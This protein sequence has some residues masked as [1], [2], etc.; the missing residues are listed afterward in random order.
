MQNNVL[1]GGAGFTNDS[2]DLVHLYLLGKKGPHAVLLMS[3]GTPWTVISLMSSH[4][5]SLEP[6]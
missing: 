1:S 5:F 3:T 6:H 4:V 2:T